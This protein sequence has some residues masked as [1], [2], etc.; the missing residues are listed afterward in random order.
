MT[1]YNNH[2]DKKKGHIYYCKTTE[3][4]WCRGLRWVGEDKGLEYFSVHFGQ[5]EE[6]IADKIFHNWYS[7]D[8]LSGCK[9]A[10]FVR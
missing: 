3:E 2:S 4:S 6:T 7:I 9:R 5:W 8:A 10:P 1:W